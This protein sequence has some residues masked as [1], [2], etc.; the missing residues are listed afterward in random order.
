MST[1]R[2]EGET[3]FVLPNDTADAWLGI[4]PSII[5]S[6]LAFTLG[7]Q[8]HSLLSRSTPAVAAPK[9]PKGTRSLRKFQ[10]Q[11]DYESASD[12]ESDAS[13]NAAALATDLSD[14]KYSSFEEMKL[15]LVVNDELKMTKG[16]IAAQAGHATLAC[17]MTLKEANPKVRDVIATIWQLL[18]TSVALQGLANARV[19][20]YVLEQVLCSWYQLFR[21]PKIA[22]RGAN[23]EEIE[24]LAA[25]ARSVN[26]CARTIRD[27]FVAF[28]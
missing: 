8:A 14:I 15:V 25:Q 22:L 20:L 16:K 13:D 24:T 7:Y 5:F 4:F 11:D 18:T 23:T 28:P 12:T 26:L 2:T 3:S 6:I 21:Q 10:Q 19:R 27:A 1:V 17:A 9:S